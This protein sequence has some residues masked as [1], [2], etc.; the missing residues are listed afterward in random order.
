ME[1]KPAFVPHVNMKSDSSEYEVTHQLPY[2]V[3]TGA[4]WPCHL[5]AGAIKYAS[6]QFGNEVWR[7]RHRAQSPLTLLASWPS[8][9]TVPGCNNPGKNPPKGLLQ[10]PVELRRHHAFSF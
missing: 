10:K 8:L 1:F 4:N 7:G 6:E 3:T 5:L 9:H 2:I